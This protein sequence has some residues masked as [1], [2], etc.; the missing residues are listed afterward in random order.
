MPTR[1]RSDPATLTV[2]QAAQRLGISRTLA[3]EL[4]RRDELPVRVIRLGRRVVVSRLALERILAD[5]DQCAPTGQ[6]PLNGR[7]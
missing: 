2:V 4:A 1:N 3:Y 7:D 5:F 6:D